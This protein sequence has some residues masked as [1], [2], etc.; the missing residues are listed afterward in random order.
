[1]ARAGPTRSLMPCPTRERSGVRLLWDSIRLTP[2]NAPK[3]SGNAYRI[4]S[5]I[6]HD[7]GFRIYFLIGWMAFSGHPTFTSRGQHKQIFAGCESLIRVIQVALLLIMAVLLLS[8]LVF[9]GCR[10]PPYSAHHH[11]ETPLGH[12][13][14]PMHEMIAGDGAQ[15][16]VESLGT[17][18]CI[19]LHGSERDNGGMCVIA[20]E[21][22]LRSNIDEV[23]EKIE[24]KPVETND[25]TID[26]EQPQYRSSDSDSDGSAWRSEIRNRFKRERAEKE[27]NARDEGRRIRQEYS[28]VCCRCGCTRRFIYAECSAVGCGH[29]FCTVC[30]AEPDASL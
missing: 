6:F 3:I 20:G 2:S 22:M 4:L 18:R 13:L 25:D 9:Q 14:Q 27:Q 12:S 10:T 30:I 17:R 26:T 8:K 21:D 23:P 5:W 24:T 28:G 11:M 1:V 15:I 16:P 19:A 29:R 7:C